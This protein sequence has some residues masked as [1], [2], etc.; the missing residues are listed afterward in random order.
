[1]DADD[2]KVKDRRKKGKEFEWPTWSS[3]F[4]ETYKTLAFAPAET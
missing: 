3:S 1:M 2:I 4:L